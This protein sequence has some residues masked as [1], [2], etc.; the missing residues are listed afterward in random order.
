MACRREST[1]EEVSET[2]DARGDPVIAARRRRMPAQS[3][4]APGSSSIRLEAGE[5]AMADTTWQSQPGSN[6]YN[7]ANN[8]S[9]G[10]PTADGI[11][12]FGSSQQ[13]ALAINTLL[14][15]GF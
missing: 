12:Y 10:A 3:P 1:A 6:D 8:W 2:N 15:P 13:T 14:M 5:I 9:F 11:A 4:E 7:D